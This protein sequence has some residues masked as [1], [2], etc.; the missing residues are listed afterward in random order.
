MK[1]RSEYN[2]KQPVK[3]KGNQLKRDF[4]LTW[5]NKTKSEGQTNYK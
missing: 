3:T 4:D 2:D 1:I 5:V